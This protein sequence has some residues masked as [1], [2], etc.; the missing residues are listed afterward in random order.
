MGVS[1]ENLP[2]T[3]SN[4]TL[5]NE[6][7]KLYADGGC[8]ILTSRILILD[9]LQKRVQPSCITGFFIYDAHRV[10]ELS[11]EAFIIRLYRRVNRDGFVKAF[12]ENAPVLSRGFGKTQKILHC[13]SVDKM[14]LWPR[15]HKDIIETLKANPP[16]VIE[17][18]QPLT[19]SME[20]I[21]SGIV[22]VMQMCLRHLGRIAKIDV[23]ECTVAKGLLQSFDHFLMERL[24]PQ[25]SLVD[26]K[27]KQM[28]HDLKILRRLL[29]CLINYDAVTF[30]RM[31]DAV[32]QTASQKLEESSGI[33]RKEPSQWLMT[34]AADIIFKFAKF[35]VYKLRRKGQKKKKTNTKRRKRQKTLTGDL[36]VGSHDDGAASE[37]Q[38]I[39]D[40]RV[41][42]LE[43][44]P[45]W[46]LLREVIQEAFAL[47]Q[48]TKNKTHSE[49]LNEKD[50]TN[51]SNSA[52]N[53][54]GCEQNAAQSTPI[55][56]ITNDDRSCREVLN[57]LRKGGDH[58]MKQKFA[59]YMSDKANEQ[60]NFVQ[61]TGSAT[62]D[63]TS[64]IN[65]FVASIVGAKEMRRQIIKENKKGE[66][67][68]R[69]ET[70]DTDSIQTSSED[71]TKAQGPQIEPNINNE[72]KQ[73]QGDENNINV[74]EL[75]EEEEVDGEDCAGDNYVSEK[76]NSV[77][78]SKKGKKG[79]ATLAPPKPRHDI[80]TK[81]FH[82]TN[83]QTVQDWWDSECRIDAKMNFKE[84]SIVD[85]IE[86]PLIVIPT[87]QESID[88]ITMLEEAKPTCIILYDPTPYAI[89]S[90]EIYAS[91]VP[92]IAVRVYFLIYEGSI[93]EQRYLAAIKEEK[94]AF[95]KLIDIK[96]HSVVR[97]DL[98]T[99]NKYSNNASIRDRN[100][101]GLG[102][103]DFTSRKGRKKA[104]DT[105]QSSKPNRVICD[106]REF[107][108]A[109]PSML[110]LR[111]LNIVPVTLTVGDY[112][113]TPH[114]V[115]ERKSLSD[116]FGS[117][118][119]GRLVTQVES[120][121]RHFNLPSLLIEFSEDR[122]F[123]LIP[124]GL[125][126]DIR[127]SHIISRMVLLTLNFPRLRLMWMRS[128]YATAKMFELLKEHEDEPD[129]PGVACA[130]IETNVN[131]EIDDNAGNELLTSSSAM[132]S[133]TNHAF[134]VVD[135]K[136]TPRDMLLRVSNWVMIE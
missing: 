108:S 63:K 56:V 22:K 38:N 60:N 20:K 74:I 84:H 73:L 95:L 116:L 125:P 91:K 136:L 82:N 97:Q 123:R 77:T 86:N 96:S 11:I 30:H 110:D 37:N 83:N 122:D 25:W 7:A 2:R 89:R 51:A 104:R 65:Q 133:A 92:H 62:N 3:L 66:A 53:V 14:F 132:A 13:L 50:A 15:F 27:S 131:G 117:F 33:Y 32:R 43:E 17:L 113:L 1:E 4:V 120:M 98:E 54:A 47:A 26:F 75:I 64:D 107:R 28:I 31:L 49:S 48:N 126:S 102:T 39:R 57:Y 18:A 55:V 52:K 124:R 29:L 78:K 10:T 135:N 130:G 24:N 36:I 5:S 79:F 128:P 59:F 44:N 134:N 46:E 69:K 114:L 94:D 19:D 80:N 115:V 121:S 112:I 71:Q 101:A 35:R 85:L 81:R 105:S 70:S 118:A 6:R 76:V 99:N 88:L 111:G 109:L 8:F 45:K 23:S 90:I 21:Q 93:E 72:M 34:D 119:S 68:K 9:L 103:L 58:Y 42:T 40:V 67:G 87:Y 127:V 100:D 41:P 106:V 16:E 61:A 129:I 12:T